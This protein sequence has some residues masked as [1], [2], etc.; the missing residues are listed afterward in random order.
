VGNFTLTPNSPRFQG[1]QYVRVKGWTTLAVM[2]GVVAR[3]VETREELGVYTAIVELVRMSD[4]A[5]ISRASP[6]GA[7]RRPARRE[8]LPT[9]L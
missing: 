6:G 1:K 3:E 9:G 5:V 4:R 8:S 7:W 2:L